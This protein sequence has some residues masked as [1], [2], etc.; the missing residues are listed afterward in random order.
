MLSV[1]TPDTPVQ[2]TRSAPL[3]RL[4]AYTQS[5]GLEPYLDRRKRGLSTLVLSLVWLVLA[6][7]GSGRPHHLGQFADPLLAALL[8]LARLPTPQTLHRSLTYFSAQA[9][10]AAVEA[11][12]RAEL[13]QRTGRIWVALDSHQVPYWG[14]G[15]RERLRKGW[16]GQHSRVLRGYRLYLATDTATG[17]VITF[18]L[19][20]GDARDARYTAVLARRVRQ[21]LGRRLAGIVADSGFTSRAAIAALLAARIP[22]ILGFARSARIR[23][24]LAALTG[25]QQRW[26]QHGGAI[27]LGWCQWDA[28]LQLLALS[29]RHP[30]DGRGPWV[31]VTSIQGLNP[32]RLA[33]LYRQRWRVE[34]A[35]DELV[36]GQDLDHLVTTRLHPNRVALGFQLLAR[37]LA[38]GFQLHAAQGRP[39]VL[40][41]PRAF[42]ATHVEG[43]GLFHRHAA[44]L[45]LMPLQPAPPQTWALPWT[46]QFI[47]L[48]A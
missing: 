47:R 14:R 7:Q 9:V 37:N 43:L 15:H 18:M 25:Q 38:L 12:Y 13:P 36:N 32:G 33:A 39:A 4:L 41:E 34:Q 6:W 24:R 40:R 1:L 46:R 48:V 20:R 45:V 17:Q 31:Y 21:L 23:A 10:R 2:P 30:T 44:T 42:R 16:S 5:L 22:F 3:V 27:R 28:R 26:L 35:L 8:G 29:A 19:R 11:A